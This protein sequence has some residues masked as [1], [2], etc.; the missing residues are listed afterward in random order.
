MWLNIPGY[1][2]DDIQTNAEYV[3]YAIHYIKQISN[4]P[5]IAVSTW[6]QG[7]LAT[8]WALKYW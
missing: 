6:S 4:V 2:L 8:Q 7:G 1:M 5:S 3:A